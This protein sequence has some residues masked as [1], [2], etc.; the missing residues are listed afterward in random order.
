MKLP[1]RHVL[2]KSTFI[3][4]A[5]CTK[6]L[7]LNKHHKEFKEEPDATQ[8][9]IFAQGTSVGELAQ[10][11][12]PGGVDCSRRVITIFRKRLFVLRP[13]LRRGPK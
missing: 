3:K 4:G 9:A 8:M 1:E 5:Q 2:S 11:L 13:K 6:A 10:Q 12:F 7:Y